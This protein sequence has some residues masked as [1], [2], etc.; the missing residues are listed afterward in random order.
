MDQDLR[1]EY[2]LPFTIHIIYRTFVYQGH[3]VN[4]VT[5]YKYLQKIIDSHPALY[6]NF[7]KAYKKDSSR[8]RLLH[9]LRSYLTVEAAC[10]VLF[11]DDC[12]KVLVEKLELW[13]F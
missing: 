10:D 6:D 11:N 8:L 3:T 7:G 9:Q 2:H 13:N 5:E 12:K 4:F 1:L